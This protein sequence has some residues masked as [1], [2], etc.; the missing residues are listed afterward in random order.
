MAPGQHD[1]LGLGLGFEVVAGQDLVLEGAE[2][3]LRCRIVD[4]PTRPIDCRIPSFFLHSRENS[5]AV[6]VDPRSELRLS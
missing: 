3:R 6:Y 5:F 1:C 4:D 2:E